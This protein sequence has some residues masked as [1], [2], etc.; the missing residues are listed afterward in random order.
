MYPY[1]YLCMHASVRAHVR[2]SLTDCLSVRLSFTFDAESARI[3]HRARSQNV[4]SAKSHLHTPSMSIH[5]NQRILKSRAWNP[6]LLYR[7]CE[8]S[9]APARNYWDLGIVY[10]T[11]V[12]ATKSWADCALTCSECMTRD[13]FVARRILRVEDLGQHLQHRCQA[14]LGHN[15]LKPSSGSR[16]EEVWHWNGATHCLIIVGTSN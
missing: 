14:I 6:H 4:I 15:A 13:I 9:R 1:G 10:I 3:E 12:I 2:M 16:V 11:H 7:A 5:S 8:A